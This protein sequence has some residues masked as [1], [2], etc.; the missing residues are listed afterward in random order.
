MNKI[1]SKEVV[2]HI[3]EE[4]QKCGVVGEEDSI[5]VLTLKTML[6]LVDNAQPTSS[7]ILISD[8]SGGGK[9]FLCKAVCNTLLEKNSTYWKATAISE[10]ALNYF[11]PTISKKPVSWNARVLYLEDPVE[12]TIK[13]QAFKVL[14]SGELE[15]ITVKDQKAIQMKIDGKP[16]IIVTSMKAQIDDEGQRRWDCI[17]IDTSPQLTGQVIINTLRRAMGLPTVNGRDDK[18]CKDLNDLRSYTVIIPWATNLLP[19]YA[20]ARM[21]DRT[22]INKLLDYIKASAIL[23]QKNRKHD[24]DGN[25]VADIEDY[26]LARFT[27]IQL[28]N[29]EGNALNKKEEI[30]L[31]YLADKGEP[32]K[33]NQ[34]T[35]ELRGVSKA[36]LYACKDA[37]VDKG[38]ISTVTKY[39]AGANREIEHLEYVQH[40]VKAVDLPSG[41]ELLQ[42]TGYIG[43]GKIYEEINKR[44]VSKGLLPIFKKM[45]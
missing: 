1:D 39:D 37:M 40:A 42:T 22:Q 24:K 32:I 35:S 33:L 2:K 31:D 12:E 30:L 21:L 34:I 27:Y 45:I 16:V 41:R 15:T 28:R 36:W 9:D 18:F 25:L 11:Q 13:S 7:N 26:E 20:K 43:S 29:K 6:R 44:R 19:A 23:H 14:A 5:I 4:I 38:I 10:K 8:I 17:R 3:I